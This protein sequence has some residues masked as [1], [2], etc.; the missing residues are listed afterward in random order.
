MF[1]WY[2]HTGLEPIY[3]FFK[4]YRILIWSALQNPI[5]AYSVWSPEVQ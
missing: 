1:E 5:K 2:T 4:T 3:F